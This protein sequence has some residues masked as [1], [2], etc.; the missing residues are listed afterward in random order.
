MSD[1]ALQVTTPTDTPILLAGSVRRT[2]LDWRDHWLAETEL[3]LSRDVQGLLVDLENLFAQSPI[4]EVIMGIGEKSR[5]R[6]D[7]ALL[8]W[9]DEVQER[10]LDRALAELRFSLRSEHLPQADLAN[11]MQNRLVLSDT[12]LLEKLRK[13][14]GAKDWQR[15]RELVVGSKPDSILLE[16]TASLRGFAT[17]VLKRL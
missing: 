11:L 10:L 1:T 16:I 4:S 15:I 6:I 8:L 7:Q 9:M 5:K 13:A 17:N 2:V 3:A 12:L 14:A